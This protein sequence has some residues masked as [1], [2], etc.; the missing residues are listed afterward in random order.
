MLRLPLLKMCSRQSRRLPVQDIIINLDCHESLPAER[1]EPFG[2]LVASERFLV[3]YFDPHETGDVNARFMLVEVRGN[4]ANE[5]KVLEY[6][7][8]FAMLR[9][10]AGYQHFIGAGVNLGPYEY[11]CPFVKTTGRLLT[12]PPSSLGRCPAAR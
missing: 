11:Y 10:G 2:V 1:M 5:E 12:W 6:G 4:E 3:Y 7:Y 8:A 9:H